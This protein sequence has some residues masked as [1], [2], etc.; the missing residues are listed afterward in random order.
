MKGREKKVLPA[1]HLKSDNV[2]R[3]GGEAASE[4]V[5]PD[6]RRKRGHP[7]TQSVTRLTRESIVYKSINA[8]ANSHTAILY[9]E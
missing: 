4:G 9:G 8:E 2:S 6:R 3:R 1:A 7:S 5:E